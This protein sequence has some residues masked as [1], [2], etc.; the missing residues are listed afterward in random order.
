MAKKKK[1]ES[2]MIFSEKDAQASPDPEEPAATA[3]EKPDAPESP[4]SIEN[5]IGDIESELDDLFEW[6]LDDNSEDSGGFRE[7]VFEPDDEKAEAEADID[8]DPPNTDNHSDSPG[9]CQADPHR[10]MGA[11]RRRAGEIQ[12]CDRP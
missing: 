8:P 3:G 6:D 7:D 12:C 1:D 4:E 9:P 11:G 5:G 2:E 10:Q